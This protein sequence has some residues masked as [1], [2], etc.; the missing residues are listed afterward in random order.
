M[1]VAGLA[2]CA[3]LPTGDPSPISPEMQLVTICSSIA[4]V[5]AELARAIRAGRLDEDEIAQVRA[6]KPV[7]DAACLDNETDPVVLLGRAHDA[8]AALERIG[9]TER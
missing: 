9:E 6:L 2:A 3:Q 5:E 4:V 7:A 1:L 8:L